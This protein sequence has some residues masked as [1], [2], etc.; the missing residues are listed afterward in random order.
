MS[1][2][3]VLKR[4]R[5]NFPKNH[6]SRNYLKLPS[7]IQ[8]SLGEGSDV[9]MFIH[10]D[11]VGKNMQE[12]KASFEGWAL[13]MKRWG[14][15]KKVTLRWEN[16]R[17]LSNDPAN[18]HY[19]RF[20]FRVG[21]FL[22]HFGDWFS[23][24][25]KSLLLQ[26]DLKIKPR[27]TYFLSQPDNNRAEPNPQ[28]PEGE[29]ELRFVTGDLKQSLITAT[30][31]IEPY[32]QLPVGVFFGE[33]SDK[34]VYAYNSIFT[35]RKSAID[36]WGFNDKNELL[37]F[38]LKAGKNRK[39]GIVSELFFY[40]CVMQLV[41]EGT[42]KF[43]GYDSTDLKRIAVTDKIK[44]FFLAPDYHPFIDKELINLLNK[45]TIPKIEFQRLWIKD[46]NVELD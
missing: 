35:R 28:L 43:K 4:L 39:V 44:A 14:E 16:P 10:K 7:D 38:E 23:V 33:E 2:D 30:N 36:I 22:D 11:A 6:K 32:R 3:E 13:V 40:S 24:H 37:L 1:N 21:C 18:G 42:F 46:T 17:F 20:L 31:C 27:T 26:R 5:E 45:G 25:P 15:Y 29:L 19:Q 34:K 41:R 9:E 12:D 8:F